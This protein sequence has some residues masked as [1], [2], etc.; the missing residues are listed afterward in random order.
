[1]IQ[2][3][4]E[5]VERLVEDKR[6]DEAAKILSEKLNRLEDAVA[7]LCQGRHWHQAW[8]DSHC[9]KR[10]DLIGNIFFNLFI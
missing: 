9:M 8:T 3:Y 4:E 6:Y 1:M 2:L 10:E 7:T 5:L